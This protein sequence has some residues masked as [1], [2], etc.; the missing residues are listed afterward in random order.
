[1]KAYTYILKCSNGSYYVGSTKDLNRRIEEHQSGEG[2]KHTKKY[3]PV[4]LIYYEEYTRIDD[5]FYREKQLQKWS[6]KKKEALINGNMKLLPDLA[7]KVFV[8]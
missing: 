6:R 8:S 1:M 5:A 7:K 3:L 4:E 2:A